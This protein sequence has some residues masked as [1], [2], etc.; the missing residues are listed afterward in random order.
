MNNMR[1]LG[2][3]VILKEV[4]SDEPEKKVSFILPGQEEKLSP[5]MKATVIASGS[6]AGFREGGIVIV[7]R[8]MCD[9]ITWEGEEL[10][11]ILSEN[12]IA[13]EN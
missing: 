2:T 8:H 5:F 4:L 9:N 3:R 7:N 13:T 1:L 12:I 6:D 10:K 11:I